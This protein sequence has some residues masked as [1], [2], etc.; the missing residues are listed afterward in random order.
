[1]VVIFILEKQP[2]VFLFAEI[3]SE[4][5]HEPIGK[6]EDLLTGESIAEQIGQLF[7]SSKLQKCGER[8]TIEFFGKSKTNF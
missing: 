3:F 1:V 8:L 7:L 4:Q 5:S 6:F 2:V